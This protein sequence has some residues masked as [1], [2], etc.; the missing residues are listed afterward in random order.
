[1][2]KKTKYGFTASEKAIQIINQ[3]LL[4]TLFSI[5]SQKPKVVQFRR[6]YK[7]VR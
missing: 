4:Q 6:N 7:M 3:V 1:M 2:E 5:N